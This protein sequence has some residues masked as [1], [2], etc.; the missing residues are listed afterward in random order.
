MV[1]IEPFTDITAD[2]NFTDLEKWG[3]NLGWNTETNCTL[4]AFLKEQGAT[5]SL[6]MPFLEAGEAFR[7]LIQRRSN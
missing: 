7:V 1:D 2:V 5:G 4:L 3:T 6:P